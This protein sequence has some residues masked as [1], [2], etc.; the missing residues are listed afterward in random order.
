MMAKNARW[1]LIVWTFRSEFIQ[2]D[3]AR[4]SDAIAVAEEWTG[5]PTR[6]VCVV[7]EQDRP[8]WGPQLDSGAL[9]IEQPF[10][11]GSGPAVWAGAFAVA[12]RDAHAKVRLLG[13]VSGTYRVAELVDHC[14]A[15]LTDVQPYTAA[16]ARRPGADTLDL[17]ALY[18]FV[19]RVDFESMAPAI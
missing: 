16:R 7:L 8:W 3:R 6:V 13:R 15:R 11:R 17:D 10:D 19:P 18:P 14:E 9:V 1:G 4:L 5:D 12:Q 2:D